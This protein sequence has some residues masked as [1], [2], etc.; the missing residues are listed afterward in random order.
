[1]IRS[2]QQ[3][4]AYER[5]GVNLIFRSINDACDY[6]NGLSDKQIHVEQMR[7]I[8]NGDGLWQYTE[9]GNTKEVFFDILED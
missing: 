4:I 8:I 9:N 2:P 1:M 5:H 7:R 3:V 6:Y